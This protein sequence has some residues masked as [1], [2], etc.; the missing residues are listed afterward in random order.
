MLKKVIRK[1]VSRVQI[2][3]S[4][5]RQTLVVLTTNRSIDSKTKSMTIRVAC[6][7]DMEKPYDH[8]N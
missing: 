6:K 3:F 5:S 4:V 2:A 8:A 1:V 7:L